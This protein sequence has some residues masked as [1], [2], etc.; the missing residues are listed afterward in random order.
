MNVVT[1]VDGSRMSKL[2]KGLNL[3]RKGLEPVQAE[4]DF[5]MSYDDG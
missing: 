5:L 2:R 4:E 3:P 1:S